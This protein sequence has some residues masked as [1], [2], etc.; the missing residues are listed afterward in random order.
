[1]KRRTHFIVLS[2]LSALCSV[3]SAAEIETGIVIDCSHPTLP[4]QRSVGAATAQHNLGQVYATRARLMTEA[5][6]ACR[7]GHAARVQLVRETAPPP[8][9]DDRQLARGDE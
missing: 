8:P 3:A 7:R 2:V 4:S 6:R 9:R 1:M 5:H